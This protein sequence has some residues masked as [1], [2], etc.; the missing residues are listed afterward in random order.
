MYRTRTIFNPRLEQNF[1]KQFEVD[2]TM[3]LLIE[4]SLSNRVMIVMQVKAEH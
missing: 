4:N 3:I 2:T 1:V